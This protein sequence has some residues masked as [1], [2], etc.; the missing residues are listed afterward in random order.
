M[1]EDAKT[2]GDIR[3]VLVDDIDRFSRAKLNEVR[4]DMVALVGS[5]VHTLHTA[6]Q[7]SYDLADEDD[8]GRNSS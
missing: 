1:L 8:L 7:G 6:A 3:A 4:S 2:K 5:G